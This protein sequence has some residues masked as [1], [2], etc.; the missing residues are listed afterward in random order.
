[1]SS[2]LVFAIGVAIL[3]SFFWFIPTTDWLELA[4]RVDPLSLAGL[5]GTVLVI[6]LCEALRLMR[7]AGWS[8]THWPALIQ[9]SF[10][11][12]LIAILPVGWLGGDAYRTYAATKLGLQ[13]N[14]ALSAVALSRATGLVAVLTITAS[15]VAFRSLSAQ[16]SDLP[17]TIPDPISVFLFCL[18][19]AAVFGV[20]VIAWQSDLAIFARLK[21][22]LS[23]TLT[24][25]RETSP[26][27]MAQ[28]LGLG[29]IIAFARATMLWFAATALGGSLGVD[30][31]LIVG[32]LALL[33]S[34]LPF[35][36]NTVGVR[37]AVTAS[38]LIGFGMEVSV[39]VATAL[40][41]RIGTV[42]TCFAGW[43]VATVNLRT[44][45]SSEENDAGTK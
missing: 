41:V 20:S 7:L 44:V 36:G 4:S 19:L 22:F 5:A 6:Q 11:A 10:G 32:G 16:R 37:E 35:L 40:L 8:M 34:L 18:T 27:V 9:F 15:A 42:L 12:S 38:I 17:L 30:T 25:I 2:V 14:A 24:S 33:V 23:N 43:G 29:V 39:A 45:G 26:N 1:V 21:S 31:S 28:A 13:A 3:A